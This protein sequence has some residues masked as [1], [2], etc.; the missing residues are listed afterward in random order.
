MKH[1]SPYDQ[2]V[3]R[4]RKWTPVAVQRGKV[5]EGAEDS[6]FR[7]LASVTLNCPSVSSYSRDLKRNYQL[8]LGYE[9]LFYLINWM[10]NAMTKLLTM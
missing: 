10:K 8:P 6:L 1:T 2:V 5:V 4:K 9:R 7:A 3:S